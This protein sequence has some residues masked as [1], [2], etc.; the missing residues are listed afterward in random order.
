MAVVEAAVS[1]RSA[2]VAG[3][4]VA[5]CG[6]LGAIIPFRKRRLLARAGTCVLAT[7]RTSLLPYGVFVCAPLLAALSGCCSFALPIQLIICAAAV[8]GMENGVRGFFEHTVNGVYANGVI[9]A[10]TFFPYTDIISVPFLSLS[11]EEHARQSDRTLV[12][13]TASRDTVELICRDAA[14]CQAACAALFAMAPLV[15]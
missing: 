13:K 12:I 14:E 10:G 4:G 8:L 9:V 11:P 2:V 1:I 7:A 5:L 3:L 15:R 6:V